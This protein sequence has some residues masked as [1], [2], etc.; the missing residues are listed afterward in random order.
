MDAGE[1]EESLDKLEDAGMIKIKSTM[2]LKRKLHKQKNKL[3]LNKN[4]EKRVQQ[5]LKKNY[6][7]QSKT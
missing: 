5:K 2:L 6:K 7:T 1:I 3:R 4:K